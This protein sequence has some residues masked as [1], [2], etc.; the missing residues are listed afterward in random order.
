MRS[1]SHASSWPRVRHT[2]FLSAYETLDIMWSWYWQLI[3]WELHTTNWREA[4][5][6]SIP[7]C[8][9]RTPFSRHE[10]VGNWH[11]GRSNKC[12]LFVRHS[13]ISTGSLESTSL[14]FLNYDNHNTFF[15]CD[16]WTFWITHSVKYKQKIW[17]CKIY[18]HIIKKL[19]G[20]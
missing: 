17:R 14:C 6:G 8:S 19:R 1:S 16:V 10:Y 15:L 20:F 18:L 4:S 2:C 11:S 5:S 13:M 3:T 9:H 7:H 12:C